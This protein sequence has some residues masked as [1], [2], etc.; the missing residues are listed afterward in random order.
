[1]VAESLVYL[2]D[3]F[4]RRL[5]G[6]DLVVPVIDVVGL[7][8]RRDAVGL[9]VGSTPY[10]WSDRTSVP[11]ASQ[12]HG[13]LLWLPRR[14]PR[15]AVIVSC[16]VIATEPHP[17]LGAG[18]SFT[19]NFADPF[20]AATAAHVDAMSGHESM[21]T[22]AGGVRNQAE[23][24]RRAHRLPAE[25]C[26][27]PSISRPGVKTKSSVG[28]ESGRVRSI[29]ERSL[30]RPQKSLGPGGFHAAA[31]GYCGSLGARVVTSRESA[32]CESIRTF[33]LAARHHQGAL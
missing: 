26:G 4:P 27:L 22:A 19:R 25:E 9:L 5:D 31:Q 13:P 28:T 24:H 2:T 16:V 15:S 6:D 7:S 29:R 21:L 33:D 3:D 14:I 17:S 10:L 20:R 12:E 8:V 11:S 23:S 1:M 18:H 32:D 30:P